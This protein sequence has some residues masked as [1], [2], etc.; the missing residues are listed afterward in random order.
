MDNILSTISEGDYLFIQFGH[1]D[2]FPDPYFYADPNTTFKTYLT[3]YIIGARTHHATPI[4]VTPVNRCRFNSDGTLINTIGDYP[5]AMIDLGAQ[6]NVPVID[7]FGK[8]KELF[9]SLGLE[10]TEKLFMIL[11]PGQYPNYPDGC[12]DDTHFIEEGACK[13]AELVVQAIK[14]AGDSTLKNLLSRT[15]MVNRQGI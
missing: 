14:K 4:L 2:S 13:I 11:N 5:R 9:E 3:Q 12:N 6:F 8:S 1:N 10:D 7:L 15:N